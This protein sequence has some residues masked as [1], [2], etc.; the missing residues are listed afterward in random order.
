[1]R[2]FILTLIVFLATACSPTRLPVD[3][4]YQKLEV[5][6]RTYR[7]GILIRSE[8]GKK[9]GLSPLRL[10]LSLKI[11]YDPNTKIRRYFIDGEEV[12]PGEKWQMRLRVYQDGFPELLTLWV[13]FEPGEWEPEI[14]IKKKES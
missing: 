2:N 12:H 7:E 13:P 8:D 1:M 6:I 10:P 5:T 14:T 3:V 4:S 9:L 11:V